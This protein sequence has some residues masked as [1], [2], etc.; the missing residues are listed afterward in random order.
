MFISGKGGRPPVSF[1]DGSERTKKRK[2]AEVN[3]QYQIQELFHALI[4]KLKDTERPKD[5]KVNI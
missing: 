3:Q 1:E 2:S 5:A 4:Q